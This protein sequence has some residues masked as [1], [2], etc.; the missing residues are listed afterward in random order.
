MLPVGIVFEP[1][2]YFELP[3]LDEWRDQQAAADLAVSEQLFW[4][5]VEQETEDEWEVN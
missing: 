5:R 4:E 2:Q 3:T 1:D